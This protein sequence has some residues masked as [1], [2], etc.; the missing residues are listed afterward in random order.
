MRKITL[1]FQEKKLNI[2]DISTFEKEY[3]FVLPE[4]YKKF[5]LE[6]NGGIPKESIFWDGTIESHVSNFYSLKYGNVTLEN[7]IKEIHREDALPTIFFPFASTG[8]GGDYAFS[9]K[10]SNF[11]EVYLF[12]YDGSEPFKICSSFD[13]FIKSLEE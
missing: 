9:L 13:D 8:G 5:L 6:N 7:I 12:H 2:E 4:S 3:K 10:D 1:E 11:G